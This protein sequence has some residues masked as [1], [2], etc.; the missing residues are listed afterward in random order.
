MEVLVRVLCLGSDSS[1]ISPI[2]SDHEVVKY[3]EPLDVNAVKD[4]S[5]DLILSYGYKHIIPER[6]LSEVKWNAI[7]MHISLLPWNKG[8]DPNFWSW[9]EGTPKGVSIHWITSGLDKGPLVAQREVSLSAA[10]SLRV[11]YGIL[12]DEICN[13]LDENW[14]SIESGYAPAINQVLRGSYHRRSDMQAHQ[15]VLAMG[16]DTPCHQLE[17][18]GLEQNLRHPLNN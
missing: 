7:N 5:P 2:L 17:Q 6:I 3:V 9:I 15:S 4:L 12:H 8:S 16:W 18:Y 1:R 14:K 13:L 10:D 11:T